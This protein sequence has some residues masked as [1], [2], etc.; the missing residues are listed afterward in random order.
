MLRSVTAFFV[1][2]YA[3]VNTEYL[4]ILIVAATWGGYP[5][6]SRATQVAGSLGALILTLCG[7]IPITIATLWSGPFVRPSSGDL[8][9]LALAG[10]LMGI[11]TA[12]FNHLATS[13]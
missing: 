13:R 1:A 12:S 2:P 5:L 10:L 4:F 7:L 11:G 6:I 8:A 9:K 3:T